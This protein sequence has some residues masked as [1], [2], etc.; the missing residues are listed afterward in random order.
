MRLMPDIIF[1]QLL[2][3]ESNR[4]WALALKRE[5]PQKMRLLEGDGNVSDGALAYT[6]T[7]TTK[8]ADFLAQLQHLSEL[9]VPCTA[10]L[11]VHE[12]AMEESF[13]RVRDTMVRYPALPLVVLSSEAMR[14]YDLLWYELGAKLVLRSRRELEPWVTL[15]TRLFRQ[16]QPDECEQMDAFIDTILSDSDS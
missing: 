6:V 9:S 8:T 13:R 5:M 15:L 2:I 16:C 14:A 1:P 7:E 11:Q 10:A 4:D 12:D 3:C